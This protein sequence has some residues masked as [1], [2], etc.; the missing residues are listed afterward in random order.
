MNRKYTDEEFTAKAHNVHDN[1]YD[2]AKTRYAGAHKKI[3]FTCPTHGDNTLRA[4]DHL[5]G[6]GCK[7]CGW[8]RLAA[9]KQSTLA[10]FIVK[11]NRVHNNRYDYSRSRYTKMQDPITIN[12]TIHG[13]FTQNANSHLMGRGCPL[14]GNDSQ[15]KKLRSNREAFIVKAR[16]IHGNKYDYSQVEYVNAHTKVKIGCAE[17]GFFEQTPHN[18]LIGH[19]C[20]KCQISK[21]EKYI[22]GWLKSH[23]VTYNREHRFDDCR[24]VLP[25]PFDFHI[26]DMNLLIEFDGRQ[27]FEPVDFFG[28]LRSF[29][30]C[31]INDTI[32]NNYA[33]NNNIPLIRIKYD[34]SPD[35]IAMMLTRFI[36]E[37]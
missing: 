15:K 37:N 28:G 21:G 27:H 10:D 7:K 35:E 23:D 32:K 33:A 3:T 6:R 25:L 22:E 9:S 17:H 24:N 31:Q 19:E 8:S 18:H 26:P 36:M 13:E 34:T 30:Q 12:C 20:A 11:A 2:Y 29:V 14:C 5:N 16:R 1:A 4:G